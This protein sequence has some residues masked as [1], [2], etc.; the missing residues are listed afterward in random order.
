[1]T[2]LLLTLIVAAFLGAFA[3][4]LVTRKRTKFF[5]RIRQRVNSAKTNFRQAFVDGYGSTA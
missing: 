5:E 3:F 4:E 2:K 1:M